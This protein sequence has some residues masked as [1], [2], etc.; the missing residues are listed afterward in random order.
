MSPAN[1]GLPFIVTHHLYLLPRSHQGISQCPRRSFQ[2]TLCRSS[3]LLLYRINRFYSL[4]DMDGTLVDSTAG[5]VGAWKIFQ[6]SYPDIDVDQILSCEH[7]LSPISSSGYQPTRQHRTEFV[8]LRISG[9]IAAFKT[10]IFLRWL[11]L[12]NMLIFL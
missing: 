7:R 10:Q 5:V 11:S 1:L 6:E 4:F 8:L 9:N 3:R 2:L 12:R